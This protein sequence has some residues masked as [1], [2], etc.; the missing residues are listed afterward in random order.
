MY[1]TCITCDRTWKLELSV[2]CVRECTANDVNILLLVGWAYPPRDR[3]SGGLV[4]CP[5][6]R[7]VQ[8]CPPRDRGVCVCVCVCVCVLFTYP[9]R[10][11]GVC[12]CVC[13]LFTCPPRDRGVCVCVYYL[14]AHHETEGRG[15]GTIYM[16]TMRPRER[17]IIYMP[18]T[19]PRERGIIYMP[20]TR[21]RGGDNIYMPTTRPRGGNT[22]YMPTTI[23][24][25]GAIYYGYPVWSIGADCFP[26][27]QR[28]L[29]PTQTSSLLH[30]VPRRHQTNIPYLFISKTSTID[31]SSYRAAP[32][33]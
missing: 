6:P 29:Y 9:P 16:P 33:C 23:P 4:R 13:V 11:R 17:G 3:G 7:K 25:E 15:G 24:R 19:R 8:A 2:L 28:P 20:T 10:D 14:H 27:S 32:F 5:H 12:V 18:T 26:D 22:I 30:H 1:S 21:P 31:H